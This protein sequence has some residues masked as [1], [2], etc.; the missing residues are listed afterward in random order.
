M[1]NGSVA[2]LRPVF[3]AMALAI[4]PIPLCDHGQSRPSA[5]VPDH[6]EYFEGHAYMGSDQV[7]WQHNRLVSVKHVAD[8][9]GSFAETVEQLDPPPE[10]WG[11]FW[12]RID[13]LGVWQWKADYYDPKRDGP[14]GESWSLAVGYGA[15]HVKSKGYNAV[16]D[17]YGAFRDA[18]HK[19]ME[20]AH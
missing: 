5:H 15:K 8:M 16:P 19:L 7:T 2:G 13:A 9:K 17:A 12:A 3:F 18:V 10:A 4:A 11:R 6:F 1:R 20:D 14:D